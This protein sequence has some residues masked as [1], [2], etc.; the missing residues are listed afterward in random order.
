MAA[1]TGQEKLTTEARHRV[2]G[3]RLVAPLAFFRIEITSI[4]WNLLSLLMIFLA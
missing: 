2:G 1:V 4:I 3:C